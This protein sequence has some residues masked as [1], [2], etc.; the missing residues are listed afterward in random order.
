MESSLEDQVIQLFREMECPLTYHEMR[1]EDLVKL[2]SQEGE[3]WNEVLEWTMSPFM[4]SSSYSLMNQKL[5]MIQVLNDLGLPEPDSF[6]NSPNIKRL[7]SWKILLQ[8][9][10][11]K[12]LDD[13]SSMSW[14]QDPF[15]SVIQINDDEKSL[16]YLVQDLTSSLD[17]ET[18]NNEND[19]LKWSLPTLIPKD[20]PITTVIPPSLDTLEAMQATCDG[21]VRAKAEEYNKRRLD[22][23]YVCTS[24]TMKN[25]KDNMECIERLQP[26]LKDFNNYY[27]S[28]LKSWV[29]LC[30]PLEQ[31]PPL[32]TSALSKN[33]SIHHFYN[34]L[35][36]LRSS[37]TEVLKF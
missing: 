19:P 16:S 37:L 1:C 34:D 11:L 27:D 35:S 29:E 6:V 18:S 12:E 17:D 30:K 26:Q 33:F 21:E 4:K 8:L 7:S 10:R 23:S 2:L 24:R 25:W 32:D 36:E 22:P 13:D 20:I 9:R 3:R 28:E 15:E 14:E 5:G 31:P